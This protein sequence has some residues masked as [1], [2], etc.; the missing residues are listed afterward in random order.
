[1]KLRFLFVVF[2]L[3]VPL[4]ACNTSSKFGSLPT[5]RASLASPSP[6]TATP[7]SPG[8]SPTPSSPSTATTPSSSAAVAPQTAPSPS[9]PAASATPS[10]P[11]TA[12]NPKIASVI[13]KWYTYYS[14]EGNFTAKFPEKPEEEKNYSSSPQG[15]ISALEVRYVDQ[16]NQRF[17]Q[18]GYANL[19][20]P[21]GAQRNRFDVEKGL[22]GCRNGMVRGLGA[23]VNKE[24]K[25]TQNGSPGREITMTLEKGIVAK[26]R[27]FINPKN[28]KAYQAIVVAPDDKLD[29]PEVKAFL[30]YVK[31]SQ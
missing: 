17:Y 14:Q 25:I 2:A 11:T 13:S 1:M 19:P 20:I 4:A 9:L 23:T 7:Y 21:P 24:R 31:I 26:A 5:S 12:T 30:D 8:A 16:V 28:L 29:L 18:T 15:P 6:K 10:S 27:I 3:V 22:D